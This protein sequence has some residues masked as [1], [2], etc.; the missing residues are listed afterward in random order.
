VKYRSV[1]R[2]GDVGDL[3]LGTHPL[4]EELEGFIIG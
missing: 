4:E 1:R 3:V 2:H